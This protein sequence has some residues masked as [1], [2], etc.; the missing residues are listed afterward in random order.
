[1]HVQICLL[2]S[3]TRVCW[4][5]G[6]HNLLRYF[7]T[8]LVGT[9]F[10]CPGCWSDGCCH[11]YLKFHSIFLVFLPDHCSIICFKMYMQASDCWVWCFNLEGSGSI[12]LTTFVVL[13]FCI[14]NHLPAHIELGASANCVL[15]KVQGSY[16]ETNLL[17]YLC[18]SL[19]CIIWVPISLHWLRVWQVKNPIWKSFDNFLTWY[20]CWWLYYMWKKKKKK[21]NLSMCILFTC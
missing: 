17:I 13:I 15:A 5:L 16:S 20:K 6:S 18:F 10:F 8:V 14:P 3:W 12:S 7:Y 1:M 21:K 11:E 4:A 2:I 9:W 19:Y